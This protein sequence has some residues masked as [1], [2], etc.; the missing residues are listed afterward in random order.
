[1]LIICLSS[2]ITLFS[3]LY[4]PTLL[5][6]ATF[7]DGHHSTIIHRGGS[8]V[9]SYSRSKQLLTAMY[10]NLPTPRSFYCNCPLRWPQVD[11]KACLY[12]QD[13]SAFSPTQPLVEFEHL[14]PM[15]RLKQ[16][17]SQQPRLAK[18]IAHTCPQTKRSCLR[19]QLSVYKSFEA[20]MLHIRPVI[21]QL[22]R[23][24]SAKWF[25]LSPLKPRPTSQHRY[26]CQIKFSHH[27]FYPPDRIKGDIGRIMLMLDR[28]YLSLK[29]FEPHELIIFD[30]WSRADPLTTTE[31]RLLNQILTYQQDTQLHHLLD[32]SHQAA[33]QP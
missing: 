2:I 6:A 16:K 15:A 1:M 18:L 25:A 32:P 14:Y 28:K 31:S 33:A 8:N 29:L 23:L 9:I 10:T 17:L 19:T 30:N 13:I 26:H 20:D 5:L 4:Q 7:N 24:R 22:N 11:L 21:K 3:A 27:Q 12:Y